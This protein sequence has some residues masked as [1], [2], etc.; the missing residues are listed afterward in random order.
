MVF[1]AAIS[2]A[3][4]FRTRQLRRLF[5]HEDAK[6]LHAHKILGAVAL[7]HFAY[8]FALWI[9]HG[10]MHLFENDDNRCLD[11]AW[12]LLALYGTHT[13][14]HVTSLQFGV[15]DRRNT[16]YN[17]IWPEMR[18]H[19][20][21]FAY[22]SLAVLFMH[23]FVTVSSSFYGIDFIS[24]PQRI[25]EIRGAI[26]LLTMAFADL[27]TIVYRWKGAKEAAAKRNDRDV[28]DHG[29]TAEQKQS[30]VY[31]LWNAASTSERTSMTMRNNPYPDYVHPS[32]AKALN[33]FYSTS[34][35]LATMN[36][37][38]SRSMDRVFAILLPIQTAPFLMT[39]EKKGVITQAGWHL[40]Y[41]L[42]LLANYALAASPPPA[43]P[44]EED[45][46]GVRVSRGAFLTLSALFAICRF[47][48]RMNKY[49]LW[50]AVIIAVRFSLLPI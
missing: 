2:D 5:T 35:V 41:T 18:W 9:S 7:L 27:V 20:M 3:V 24:S 47:R 6:Y 33:L 39:L 22:R 16:R 12:T 37:L 21:I 13:L 44:E 28:D 26:V 25:T 49:L 10:D 32:F 40:Y 29:H 8:R 31:L 46:F 36:V 38:T 50:T 23:W 48:L 45:G 14:L 17:V 30:S 15:P 43:L 19:T 42:S 1:R 34:Q 11:R 4:T